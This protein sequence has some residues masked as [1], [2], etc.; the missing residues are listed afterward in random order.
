MEPIGAH[1]FTTGT[2]PAVSIAE[3][4]EQISHAVEQLI[5]RRREV[6]IAYCDL[7]GMEAYAETHV[8]FPRLRRLCQMLIDYTALGHFEI[9]Q[10]I[11]EGKE[12]RTPVLDVAEQVYPALAETT[13]ALV[14]FNDNYDLLEDAESVAQLA[15]D[16]SRLGETFAVRIE[17]EDRILGALGGIERPASQ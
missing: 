4:R 6:M 17:L 14:E 1:E 2:R 5:E 12:R 7:A 3:R 15:G 13:D 8:T 10:R 9:Y 11:V 16:L